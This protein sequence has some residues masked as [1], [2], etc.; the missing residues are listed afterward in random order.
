M[1][2]VAQ[3]QPK[4]IGTVHV[5]DTNSDAGSELALVHVAFKD[6]D[7][8]SKVIRKLILC[9]T[10]ETTCRKLRIGD[11]YAIAAMNDVLS[12]YHKGDRIGGYTVAGTVAVV[13]PSKGDTWHA[14]YA[15]VMKN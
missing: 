5:M 8:E 14:I 2:S 6:S 12:P 10:K 9:K 13:P 4:D 7:G 3:V 15:V 11:Y 1:L